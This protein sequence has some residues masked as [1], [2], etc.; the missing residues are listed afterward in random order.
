MCRSIYK[1]RMQRL[2][3]APLGHGNIYIAPTH[4]A[5]IGVYALAQRWLPP[6]DMPAIRISYASV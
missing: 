2:W 4:H 1:Q 3:Y 5:R 6:S